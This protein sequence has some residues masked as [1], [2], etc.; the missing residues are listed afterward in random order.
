MAQTPTDDRHPAQMTL[1]AGGLPTSNSRGPACG[2]LTLPRRS[3][4]TAF[5]FFGASFASA[6]ISSRLEQFS[7]QRPNQRKEEYIGRRSRNFQPARDLYWAS[8]RPSGSA[9]HL[10]AALDFRDILQGTRS[11]P[12]SSSGPD[13]RAHLATFDMDRD[14]DLGRARQEPRAAWTLKSTSC[15]PVF[16]DVD[17]FFDPATCGLW[18]FWPA[19]ASLYLMNLPYP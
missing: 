14:V 11:P 7:I 3:V 18:R 1:A 2:A 8:A 4:Y 6:Y 15:P 5:S 9:F 13:R 12:G 19:C 16:S 10:T 17:D